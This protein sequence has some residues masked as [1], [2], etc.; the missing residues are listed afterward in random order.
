M[1]VKLTTMIEQIVNNG[2][3]MFCFLVQIDFSLKPCQFFLI[4]TEAR[5]HKKKKHTN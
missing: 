3:Y 1:H 5:K 2:Q 4:M